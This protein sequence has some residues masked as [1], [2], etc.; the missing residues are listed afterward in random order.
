MKEG[1]RKSQKQGELGR[2]KKQKDKSQKTETK[3]QTQEKSRDQRRQRESKRQRR[4][5]EEAG[6]GRGCNLVAQKNKFW[7]QML[8]NI[9]QTEA[10]GTK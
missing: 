5:N 3:K 4:R 10:E 7:S 1:K 6:M 9:R 2:E 8:R